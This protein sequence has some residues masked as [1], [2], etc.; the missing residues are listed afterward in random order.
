[1]VCVGG[2]IAI[3]RLV[4]ASAWCVCGLVPGG[5][6]VVCGWHCWWGGGWGWVLRWLGVWASRRVVWVL[7][8]RAVRSLWP[9]AGGVAEVWVEGG[10]MG[11]QAGLWFVGSGWLPVDGACWYGVWVGGL[12][13]VVGCSY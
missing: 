12:V 10:R 3:N 6:M 11:I 9:L 5:V 8:L 4:G 2:G 7:R 13:V 1:M